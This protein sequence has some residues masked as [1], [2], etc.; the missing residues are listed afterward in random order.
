MRILRNPRH[1]K[2]ENLYFFA[3]AQRNWMQPILVSCEAPFRSNLQKNTGPVGALTG[4][5]T[6]RLVVFNFFEREPCAGPLIRYEI[7]PSSSLTPPCEVFEKN[8]VFVTVEISSLPS[9]NWRRT[10]F[11]LGEWKTHS[12]Q[13]NV[14]SQLKRGHFF[15]CL[16]KVGR[17]VPVYSYCM[18]V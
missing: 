8:R 6:L 12:L 2:N 13:N 16:F 5:L 15:R 9:S 7:L 3:P 4:P 18:Y 14:F 11:P 17:I 1:S 10:I